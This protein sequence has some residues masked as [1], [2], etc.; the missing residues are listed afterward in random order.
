M[1]KYVYLS[2]VKWTDLALE[3]SED[4][5]FKEWVPKHD[6]LC[7][8][9]KVTLLQ[10]GIPFGTVEEEVFIYETELPLADYQLF[11]NDVAAICK[12]RLV[13]WTNTTI[14]NCTR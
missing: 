2:F 9:H 3:K 4:Y 1:G 7:K 10:E 13:A 5:W 6:A 14:V 8:K 12:E 11:R